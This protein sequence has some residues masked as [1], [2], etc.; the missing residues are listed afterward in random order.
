MNSKI[1]Q[2]RKSI[3]LAGC[4][5]SR[6]GYYFVTFATRDLESLFGVCEN[7]KVEL[8][9]Y[10]RIAQEEWLKT[11]QIRPEVKL[12]AFVIMP[13]H[14][15]G[16]LAIGGN[17]PEG[18]VLRAD[19]EL[20]QETE[21]SQSGP[22]SGSIGAIIGQFKS[23]VSKRINALRGTPGEAV[24]HRNYYERIIRDEAGLERVRQYIIA[25]PKTWNEDKYHR[26]R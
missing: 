3:R 6:R 15:H 19:R 22:K 26:G 25:N 10:G 18:A 17:L 9:E 8:S 21:E 23:V 14:I 4:D 13:N 20:E 16:I 11:A 24:W 5:Y 2:P 1:I 7:G 12:D